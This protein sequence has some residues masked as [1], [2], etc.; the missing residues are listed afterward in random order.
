M[1]AV[2][3]RECT[4][5]P[6]GCRSEQVLQ[7]HCGLKRIGDQTILEIFRA[8]FGRG[9]FFFPVSSLDPIHP[10]DKK[11]NY[12]GRIL[13]LE[14][15][16]TIALDATLITVLFL[17]CKMCLVSKIV[18]LHVQSKIEWDL[19]NEPRSVSCVRAIRYSG[20]GVCSVGPTVGDFLDTC[21]IVGQRVHIRPLM[22]LILISY[23]HLQG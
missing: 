18:I 14:V 16:I 11:N 22:S 6:S 21:M 7:P 13:E 20:L 10:G 17:P 19:T 1:R 12:I 15:S 23:K 2:S 4:S 9:A 8:F 3:F 5:V